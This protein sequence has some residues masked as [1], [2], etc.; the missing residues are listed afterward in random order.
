MVGGATL[1][2]LIGTSAW[3][4]PGAAVALLVESIVRNQKHIYPCSVYLEGEYGQR[5]ICLGVPVVIGRNGWERIVDY[6]LNAEEQ[7]LFKK[8]GD[9]V[10]NMNDVLSTLSI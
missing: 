8:S 10:R 5:D 9:A 1:T 3:Y 6:K 4:A 2:K 7:E